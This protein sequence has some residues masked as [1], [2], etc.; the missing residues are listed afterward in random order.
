MKK[1]YKIIIGVALVLIVC[2]YMGMQYLSPLAVTGEAVTAAPLTDSFTVQG[3]VLPASS[4][5]LN[6]L[7]TGTVHY[8]PFQ[9]G[10]AVELGQQLIGVNAANPAELA[11]QKEQLRQQLAS[12][13]HQYQ[14]MFS[15]RG[16]AQQQAAVEAANSAYQLAQSQ[17]QAALQV[18]QGISGVYTGAQLAELANAVKAAKQAVAAAEAQGGTSADREY[19]RTLIDSTRAQ[20]AALEEDEQSEP[21]LAPFS[22]VVWEVFTDQGSYIIKNQP[23]LKLYQEG[24]MK[25]EVSL[26]SE[27]SL[28]IQVGDTAQLRL[29]GGQLFAA[30][31]N[32]IS[33]VAEQVVSS[34]GLTEN[35]CTV[36][37]QPQNL[38]PT[39]GAGHQLDVV[40]TNV[41]AQSALS[42]PASAI[43]PLGN[44][45]S[46]VYV[47]EGGKARLVP[48][49]TGVKS[50]GRVEIAGG[51]SAGDFVIADPYDA[52]IKEGSRVSYATSP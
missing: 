41:L 45:G 25:V 34:L 51:L 13:E 4:V 31:V 6:S 37:L 21:L 49:Q 9:P 38:P 11:I 36:E 19:F 7:A 2:G 15:A 46:A 30:S 27:D 29:A 43:V 5:I 24:P 12:A 22:G 1:K 33:P 16:L 28:N 48:V 23:V 47:A 17:Y 39:L 10:S 40:F 52:G 50:G 35:R 20:L 14:Q 3:R 26:L 18:E 32:F 8:F 44:G 42:V